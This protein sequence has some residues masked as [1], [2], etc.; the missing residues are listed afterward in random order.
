MTTIRPLPSAAAVA[1]LA[2]VAYVPALFSS[3]GRMPA[4]TKL[5][6]YLDPGGL[7]G[8][9][10][11][12]FEPDQ[13]AGWVPHQQITY[14]WPSGPWFWLFDVAGVPDWIAHRLW[15]GSIMFLAG[16]G[17][18]WMTRQL[19]LRGSAALAAALCYELSPFLLPYIS[20]TS[21]L[22]LP[23]AGLGWIVGLTVRATARAAD[24]DHTE[25]WRRRLLPWR[26]PAMIALVVATVGSAN[27]TALALIAPA[28]V[29]WLLHTAWSRVVSW[30]AATMIAL[31]V[32]A[33]C[34]V[35]SLW[36]MAMLVVQSRHGAPVLAYS[37]TLSDVS[38]SSTG[39]EVLRGLGYWLF[40]L[41]DPF[42]PTTS[43]SFAYLVSTRVIAVSYAVTLIGLAGIAMTSSLF[44]RYA[45]LLVLTG[46]ILSVGV[47][48]IGSSS[49]LMS[50]L[51]TDDG[52]GLALALR[53]ST[54]ALPLL[55]LGLALGVG[56][57]VAAIPPARPRAVAAVAI[58]L[59]VGANMP[60]LWQFQ[61]V[62][63][64][65]DRD[66][67]PPTAWLDA[68]AALDGDGRVLQ[69]PGAEFGAF[70]WGYTVD[71]PL[72]GLT[73]RPQVTRDLLPLGGA[74][75]MD[76]LY[77]LDDRFQ[78][79]T[80]EPVSVAPVARLLG[81]DT[82][83]V[84]N[85][86]EF[87]RFRTPRPEI[88]DDLLV[89]AGVDGLGTARTF[90]DPFVSTPTVPMLDPAS[91]ADD[92]VGTPVAPVALVGVD[93][94][95]GVVRAKETV[96]LLAGSGDGVVDAA[97]AGLL[98][99]H[100][101]VLYTGALAGLGPDDRPDAATPLIVTDSNRDRAHHWRGSQDVHGHTEPGGPD[102]DVLVRTNADQRLAVFDGDDPAVQTVAVQ[103]GPVTAVASAYGE[104]FAYLPEH[105]ALMAIDG[106]P[107]TAWLV[108]GHGDPIGERIQL[109]VA[110]PGSTSMT[111]SQ[112]AP[113]P[114]GRR[115]DAVRVTVDGDRS[116]DVELTD[117]STTGGQTVELGAAPAHDVEIEI[118]GVTAGEPGRAASRAA[119]GFAEIDLGLGPTVELIRPPQAALD[120]ATGPL[121]LVLTRLRVDPLDRWRAD[122]EPELARVFRLPDDRVLDATVTLRFDQRAA[123]AELA[124]LLGA[125]PEVT[126]NGHLTGAP[127]HRG[128]AALDGDPATAWITPFDG[129]LGARLTIA[130]TGPV[131]PTVQIAQPT[132]EFA[133]TT[134][135]TFESDGLAI[136][137]VVPEPDASGVSTIELAEPLPAGELTMTITGTDGASTVD[138]RFGDVV[139]LPAAIAE[140]AGPGL[141]VVTL[142]EAT[143]VP[144]RRTC[145]PDL[146]EIDGE[147]VALSLEGTLDEVLDG[148][149][150]EATLCSPLRLAA[151]EHRVI[152]TGRA[153]TGLS[154]DRLVLSDGAAD[155]ASP[156]PITVT[157]DRDDPRR[158]TVTVRGCDDGCWLVLGEG[159]N[160]AWS[161]R[162]GGESLGPP[163]L[164]DGGFNG[165]RLPAT[166][167]PITV[168][169]TWTA[170]TPVTVGLLLSG[171]GVLGCLAILVLTRGRR[172]VLAIASPTMT[173]RRPADPR[174]RATTSAIA[175]V[176]ASTILIGPVWGVIS[177][178]PAAGLVL[179]VRHT[180]LRAADRLLELVG[181]SAAAI[182]ALATIAIVRRNRPF[183]NAAWTEGV[184]RLNG[185]AVFSVVCLAVGTLGWS[186]RRREDRS[187]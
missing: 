119:V 39:S 52:S 138:R 180:S 169:L 140:L 90:G 113:H 186:A 50:L 148:E 184:E 28:P 77:A 121:S 115:I 54:R 32:A 57:L 1:I 46:V 185:L 120:A 158:R 18:Y 27:A 21:L 114:G 146:L 45:A 109:T 126:A 144:S 31:R 110:D 48:P 16:W 182:V 175:L 7:V 30:G 60:S 14:L 107:R 58:I 2:F 8:R 147:P 179:L 69:L 15:I 61:L 64:A 86:S 112:P 93:D 63:R 11:S 87:E 10:P 143:P 83:W 163:V 51:S 183:P 150:I 98:S 173:W 78:E 103:D 167:G 123:D 40:Y 171:V 160:D 4:D 176:V 157:S 29:L 131:G 71:Q 108:G 24:G 23:W 170:Q 95:L 33:L 156:S 68:A 70:R 56:S 129:A 84:A 44:R 12:T 53:S 92:R 94:P 99:G 91:L 42:A 154:V 100:E 136:D 159:F 34:V 79:G 43:A 97:A 37:E 142:D 162:A 75:A 72:A 166:T 149:P 73:D 168:E 118:A 132:G 133:T 85:D 66:E 20:R 127:R 145:R 164:V 122:P 76:L 82:I 59:V 137:A 134:S 96:V 177:L 101:L 117:D 74:P 22:L 19:G 174:R 9:A 17:V 26:E 161:A 3:P 124:A 102:D 135:V 35:V 47:H 181:W 125:V 67:S 165:W 116:F 88:V 178:V 5:Y 62:D 55:V 152:S 187:A 36:W 106:D 80:A 13:F 104:P 105:R 6:L 49:P 89:D 151:G 38:R 155:P 153:A 25:G 172:P 130:A 141:P 139:A 81:A 128:A 65:I 41:R 111:L